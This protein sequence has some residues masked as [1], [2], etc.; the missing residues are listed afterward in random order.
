MDVGVTVDVGISGVPA[1]RGCTVYTKRYT[2]VMS[3]FSCSWYILLELEFKRNRQQP[4]TINTPKHH[5]TEKWSYTR[6]PNVL[7]GKTDITD[8]LRMLSCTTQ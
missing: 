2:G 3:R 7:A 1:R 6:G 5:D 4:S 8:L